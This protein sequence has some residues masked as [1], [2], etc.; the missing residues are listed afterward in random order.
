MPIS[1]VATRKSRI[2]L[3]ALILAFRMRLNRERSPFFCDITPPEVHSRSAVTQQQ[4]DG[5]SHHGQQCVAG[6]LPPN[7]AA[8]MFHIAPYR[9]RRAIRPPRNFRWRRVINV[10]QTTDEA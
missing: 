5:R 9:N 8:A 10:A 2:R 3:L 7:K 4:Y 1:L 6:N